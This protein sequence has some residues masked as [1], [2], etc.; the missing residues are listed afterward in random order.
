MSLTLETG[1]NFL[2]I[3]SFRLHARIVRAFGKLLHFI[4]KCKKAFPQTPFKKTLIAAAFDPAVSAQHKNTAD[5]K[6]LGLLFLFV[7]LMTSVL[8]RQLLKSFERGSGGKL[9]YTKVFPQ[10]R[11]K[12]SLLFIDLFCKFEG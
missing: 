9:L 7:V 2:V 5:S 12:R 11:A 1:G 8:A 3:R 4:L 6:V 10:S